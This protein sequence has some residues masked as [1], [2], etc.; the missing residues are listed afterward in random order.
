[1]LSFV[2]FVNRIS[3]LSLIEQAFHDLLY[4]QHLTTPILDFYGVE[5]IGKTSI[6]TKIIEKCDE[7]TIPYISAEADLDLPQFSKKIREQIKRYSKTPLLKDVEHAEPGELLRA[8]LERGP[9]VMLLDAVDTTNE[10]QLLQIE[11]LLRDLIIYNKFF[12]VLTSRR[13]IDF[14]HDKSVARKLLVVPVQ[15]L[16]RQG[17]DLY[18]DSINFP[19]DSPLRETIFEWTRGYPLAMNTMVQALNEGITPTEEQ[20]R[21]NLMAR[22]VESVIARR[23]LAQV[24]TEDPAWIKTALNLLAVPRRFNLV[25]M[26]KLIERFEPE[27]SLSN[28]LAY[29]T[30]P[31]RIAKSTGVIGWDLVKAGFAIDEP[32]RNI[33][34]LQLKIGHPTRYYEINSFLAEMNWQNASEVSGSDRIR[35]QREYLYHRANNVEESLVPQILRDTV[36]NIIQDAEQNID[37]LVQFSTEFLQDNELKE[38]LGVNFPLVLEM[39]YSYLSQQMQLLYEREMDD[40]KRFRYL[41]DF[42]YYTVR[43]PTGA[44]FDIASLAATLKE[45]ILLLQEQEG[46]RHMLKLYEDLGHDTLFVQALGNEYAVLHALLRKDSDSSEE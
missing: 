11:N 44:N 17:T 30:L 31:K 43:N 37:Q 25:I 46:A 45:R 16:D 8:L 41:R 18:L 21:Q 32:V 26:Q 24:K 22:I 39:L 14:E 10:S 38:E 33:L 4:K 2:S 40:E 6:L 5:G 19:A 1:M 15:P 12:V 28:S 20:G 36:V 42:F 7:N 13:R 34:L 3:E 23:L 35:Y 29:M 9:L 27:L